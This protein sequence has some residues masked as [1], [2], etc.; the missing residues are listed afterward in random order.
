MYQDKT[1][2][3][4]LKKLPVNFKNTIESLVFGLSVSFF[5]WST[6]QVDNNLFCSCHSTQKMAPRFSLAHPKNSKSKILILFNL[7]SQKPEQLCAFS[8]IENIVVYQERFSLEFS[9][10]TLIQQ[11]SSIVADRL[12]PFTQGAIPRKGEIANINIGK[13]YKQWVFCN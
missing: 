2:P 12:D 11:G 13:F 4:L 5:V 10:S 6:M 9:P 1:T 3:K 8:N 7:S